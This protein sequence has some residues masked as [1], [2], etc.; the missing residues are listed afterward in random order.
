MEKQSDHLKRPYEPPRI[1]ELGSIP[2]L[3]QVN[4]LPGQGG[5]T[6]GSA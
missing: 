1:V 3:T 6:Q 2:T 5:H 4:A